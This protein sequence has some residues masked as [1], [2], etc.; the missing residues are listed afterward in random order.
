MPRILINQVVPYP[1]AARL[2]DVPAGL[3]LD[4]L[5]ETMIGQG[6]L[7]VLALRF[8]TGQQA[9]AES[10]LGDRAREHASEDLV[11]HAL[12][13]PEDA[14]LARLVLQGDTT[15]ALRPALDTLHLAGLA[16]SAPGKFEHNL[17][18]ILLAGSAPDW[19][20]LNHQLLEALSGIAVDVA[21]CPAHWQAGHFGLFFKRHGF[22]AHQH[23]MHRRARRHGRPQAASV[24]HHRTGHAG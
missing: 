11:F 21:L 15:A 4:S 12:E 16:A 19:R 7:R 14:A 22:H 10:W 3:N 5:G 23:R 17:L 20:L 9:L 6:I 18:E 1:E 13:I 8:E 24:S 2:N